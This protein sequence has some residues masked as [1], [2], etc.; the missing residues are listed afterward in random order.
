LSAVEIAKHES[1]AAVLALFIQV[2]SDMH[3]GKSLLWAFCGVKQKHITS[4]QSEKDELEIII[5]IHRTA[6]TDALTRMT[7]IRCF[8]E[9][10]CLVLQGEETEDA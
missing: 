6:I 5:S 8:A 9:A 7:Q 2:C 4:S 10:G 3:L 1:L